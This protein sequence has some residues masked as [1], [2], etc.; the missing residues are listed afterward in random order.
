VLSSV[1]VRLT[2]WYSGALSCVL[3][4][5]AVTTYAVL[6]ENFVRRTDM[7]SIELADSFLATFHAE[8]GD[9]SNPNRI[10]ESTSDALAEHRFRDV[11]FAVFDPQG[12]LLGLSE[13]YSQPGHMAEQTRE[14]FAA[15]LKPLLAEP[16]SFRV[17]HVGRSKYRSCVRRF[18]VD[19]Q[20]YALVVLQSLRRQ[21][22]FLETL[23]GT[24]AIIIP[25]TI[26]LASLGGYFLARRSLAPVAR[27]SSQA[28]HIG[29]ENLHERLEV[30]NP[31]DEL[32]QLA[33]SFNGLLN[34]VSQSFDR[35]RRFVADASHELRTPVA[36][37]YGE[38]EVTLA[39]PSRTES[40]YRE[41]LQTLQEEAKRLK[42]IVEDLF[43]LARADAGQHPLV[44]NDFYLDE[45]AA[46]CSRSVR[47][48]AAAK[49]ITVVCAAKHE[50]PIHADETLLR[51]MLLNL[52][53]NAIKYTPRGGTVGV[54][55]AEEDGRYRLTFKDSGQGIP[56]ELQSRIFERF[57]RA[58]KARSRGESDAG[59]AG[60]GLPIAS[61]IAA[62]HGG[63][64]ELTQSSPDGSTFTVFLPKATS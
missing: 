64:L 51:R 53:D 28:G 45:L 31:D 36:I 50:L 10:L 16:D 24:F 54:Q 6:K 14:E 37:L 42:H 4:V 8:L 52:L 44:L 39:Q 9:G 55:C 20:P 21:D 60:L 18:F 40:E 41:S 32:G 57:F 48:L 30:N 58:D 59:G 27:M 5:L 43:T 38:A 25:L 46:E 63:T 49:Q 2:L 1:R 7:A 17:A 23:A 35:Q 12:A 29:S 33:A 15:S 61:W 34:R 3:L 26:A 62:A 19:Q 13:T 22:D 11:V 47:T 56:S